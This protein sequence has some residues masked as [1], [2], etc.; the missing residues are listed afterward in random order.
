MRNLDSALNATCALPTSPIIR[1]TSFPH[2]DALRRRAI[3]GIN[4]RPLPRP[5]A[6]AVQAAKSASPLDKRLRELEAKRALTNHHRLLRAAEI[7]KLERLRTVNSHKFFMD[8]K[9]DFAPDVPTTFSQAV[10]DIPNEPGYPPAL[11]RFSLFFREL[12]KPQPP[13]PAA[14][15]GSRWLNYVSPYPI[16]AELRLGRPFTAAE[17]L[18][19]IFPL[20]N[21]TDFVC[22]ATGA[23]EPGCTLCRTLKTQAANW[24]GLNDVHTVPPHHHPR[25]KSQSA[26]NGPHLLAFLSWS[27]HPAMPKRDYRLHICGSIAAVLNKILAEGHMPEGTTAY[28]SVP[29]R[30]PPSAGSIP[31]YAD[32]SSAYRFISMGP[33]VTK[34]LCLAIDARTIHYVTARR[35]IDFSFQGASVPYMSTEWHTISLVEAV[36]AEWDNN[37]D[38]FLL[39][40]D[41]KK[42]YDSVNGEV[43]TAT[44]LRLGFPPNLVNL[45]AHWNLTRTTT[46]YVNGVASDPIPTSAGIGQGDVFSCV[47]YIIF[48]N[49]LYNFL[50]SKGLGVTPY[51]GV[52]DVARGFVD[53]VAALAYSLGDLQRTVSAVQEWGAAFNH[54]VQSGQKKTAV[55]HLPVPAKL[56]RWYEYVGSNP[57]VIPTITPTTALASGERVPFVSNYK[58]LGYII[59]ANLSEDEHLRR[60]M[61]HI[62]ANHS[63][64]FGYNHTLRR[65]S[66]TAVCQILKTTCLP[67]Y[68]NCMVNPTNSN[69]SAIDSNINSLRRTLLYGLPS[70]SPTLF[71]DVESSIPSARFFVTRSILTQLLNMHISTYHDAPAVA[72]YHAQRAVLAAGGSLPRRAWLRRALAYLAPY[73]PLLGDYTDIRGTLR[74]PPGRALT[75]S[76]AS[77]AAVVYARRVCTAATMSNISA[78]NT[79]DVTLFSQRPSPAATAKQHYVDLAFGLAHAAAPASYPS[80]QTPLSF[81]AGGGCANLCVRTTSPMDTKGGLYLRALLSARLGACSLHYAPLGPAS[82]IPDAKAVLPVDYHHSIARGSPCPL[83]KA[84]SADPWHILCECPHSAVAAERARLRSRASEYIPVLA[85]HI[86]SAS[87]APHARELEVAYLDARNLP[88]PDWFSPSGQ[89]LLFRLVMVLPWPATC[90]DDPLAR[91]ALALG[92]IMDLTVVRNNRLHPIADSWVPWG[93]KR[94]MSIFSVWSGAV[95]GRR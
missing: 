91:H 75:P 25:G 85:E 46:L 79:R 74:L 2:D 47:L 58:Y 76:D 51:P 50:K 8:I 94:L 32:P 53:D 83:C 43:L 17:L 73:V 57:A 27:Q 69:F 33:L 82:W 1:N 63:R 7:K 28:K 21:Y 61:S 87:P 93:A 88:A 29:L 13:P 6:A 19:L 31:N 70:S 77:L 22:P 60:L 39:F 90:V 26:I 65:L 16:A 41:F 49:S 56:K 10:P 24:G 71:L 44:L 3:A 67:G 62:S 14:A 52:R 66:P 37:H 78:S 40:I 54:T 48:I 11:E 45:L 38:L 5:V 15:P 36:K 35:L 18:P 92:T 68:L 12:Y 59:D 86:F 55:L 20:F 23:P 80:K 34:I 81:M 9:G 72:A 4:N 84:P 30:K 95:D 64:F 89:A 42:A